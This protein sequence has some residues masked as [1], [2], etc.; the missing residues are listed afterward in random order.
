MLEVTFVICSFDLRVDPP[1][2]LELGVFDKT[3]VD[4]GVKLGG[5]LV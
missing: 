5:D 3:K 1:K 2:T 4:E